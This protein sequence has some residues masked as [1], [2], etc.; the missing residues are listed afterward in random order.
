M[1]IKKTKLM[2]RIEAKL[3]QPI[4]Q[5]LPQMISEHG[6]TETASQLEVSTTTVG[7]WMLKLGIKIRRVAVPPQQA[8]IITRTT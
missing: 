8:V 2:L 5:I 3:E 4:E 1:K 7:Y 6:V